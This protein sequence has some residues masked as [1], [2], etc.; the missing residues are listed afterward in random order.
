MKAI[1]K[2]LR[3]IKST[4]IN[5]LKVLVTRVK[6][7]LEQAKSNLSYLDIVLENCKGLAEPKLVDDC[8]PKILHVVRFVWTESTY[9]NEL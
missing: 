7:A 2:Q 8:M 1:I 3:R 9:Y 4:S 6:E 5:D